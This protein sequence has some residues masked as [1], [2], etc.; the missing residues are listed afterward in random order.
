MGKARQLV[1]ERVLKHYNFLKKLS[2]TKSEKKHL[3]LLNNAVCDELLCLVE[4]GANVLTGNFILTKK[5][6]LMKV[7]FFKTGFLNP[8]SGADEPVNKN[9]CSKTKTSSF[10]LGTLLHFTEFLETTR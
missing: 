2:K 10:C 6:L 3:K 4:A 1:G 8:S 7:F 5:F 9:F